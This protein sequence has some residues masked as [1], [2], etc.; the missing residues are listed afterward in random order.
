MQKIHLATACEFQS[1]FA[2]AL[3]WLDWIIRLSSEFLEVEV[4]GA[5]LKGRDGGQKRPPVAA[6]PWRR[7]R[8]RRR[9]REFNQRS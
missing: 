8:R 6:V 2:V 4:R 9:R 7:R 5:T 3:P 1:G